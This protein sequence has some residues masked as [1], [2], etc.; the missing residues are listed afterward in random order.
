MRVYVNIYKFYVSL[1]VY[2]RNNYFGTVKKTQRKLRITQ[3]AR[4]YHD[5][6]ARNVR[7]RR[8]FREFSLPRGKKPYTRKRYAPLTAVCVTAQNKVVTGGRI[9]TEKLRLVREQNSG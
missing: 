5:A 9:F 2:V 4:N 3:P 7:S 6:F 8:V 1:C